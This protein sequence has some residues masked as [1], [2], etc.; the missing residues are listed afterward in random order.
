MVCCDVRS[1][2]PSIY[3]PPDMAELQPRS[4]RYLHAFARTHDLQ[5][6]EDRRRISVQPLHDKRNQSSPAIA[7]ALGELL[8]QLGMPGAVRTQSAPHRLGADS[9]HIS[10]DRLVQMANVACPKSKRTA[11]PPNRTLIDILDD[12]DAPITAFGCK[13]MTADTSTVLSHFD[14]D[15]FRAIGYSAGK[16]YVMHV[17]LAGGTM[18]DPS[19]WASF[20][21][22][23][24]TDF[25]FHLFTAADARDDVGLFYATFYLDVSGAPT[26]W[27]Q[28]TWADTRITDIIESE[29]PL[30]RRAG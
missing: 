22:L 3:V 13:L 23:T 5:L 1:G 28:N 25:Q 6:V 19:L 30:L 18:S 29:P 14:S 24:R 2:K 27:W 4:L 11:I 7:R 17:C 26:P 16:Q 20:R 21:T 8:Q 10:I 9:P 15:R 12:S